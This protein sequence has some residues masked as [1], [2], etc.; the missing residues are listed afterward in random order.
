MWRLDGKEKRSREQQDYFSHSRGPMSTGADWSNANFNY[1]T[2]TRVS[3]EVHPLKVKTY[4]VWICS[5][6]PFLPTHRGGERK[7]LWNRCRFV[8]SADLS[9]FWQVY[10]MYSNETETTLFTKTTIRKASCDRSVKTGECEGSRWRCSGS[11]HC[12]CFFCSARSSKLTLQPTSMHFS[13]TLLLYKSLS[14]LSPYLALISLPL[15]YL[16]THI[17]TLSFT[18][19]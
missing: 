14:S 5:S 2:P 6:T 3:L 9:D 16:Y 7:Q 10:S 18:L 13:W 8:D 12:L 1:S 17:F 11:E 15:I 4:S 19:I